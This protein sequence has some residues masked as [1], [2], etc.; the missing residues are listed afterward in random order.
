MKKVRYKGSPAHKRDPGDFNLS[1]PAAPRQNATLCDEA[2]VFKKVRAQQ[3]LKSGVKAGLISQRSVKGYPAQ[4]WTVD[5][6]G[7]V[8]EAELENSEQGDYHG[9]PLPL[10]D[11][12]R[13]V[14]LKKVGLK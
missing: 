8:F 7:V 14:V 9:Y 4:I 11:P 3:L 1:P 5:D 12:F 13:L 2:G 10:A 6:K